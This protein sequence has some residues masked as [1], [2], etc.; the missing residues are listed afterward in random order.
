MSFFILWFKIFTF[1]FV[2]GDRI[3]RI[4][5][6]RHV[7]PGFMAFSFIWFMPFVN[8]PPTGYYSKDKDDQDCDKSVH[9]SAY[10]KKTCAL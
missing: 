9:F 1:A 6:T 7:V 8:I 3:M 10:L 5:V 2:S 4:A